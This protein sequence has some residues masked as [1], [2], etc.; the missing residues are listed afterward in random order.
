MPGNA[1]EAL[2]GLAGR[3]Q[4]SGRSARR[5]GYVGHAAHAHP[6]RL[7]RIVLVDAESMA[8]RLA[9]AGMACDLQIGEIGRFVRSTVPGSR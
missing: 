2:A 7:A 8:D 1:L 3:R 9:D 4:E 5:R 6:G